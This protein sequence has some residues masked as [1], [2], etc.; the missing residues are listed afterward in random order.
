MRKKKVK[1]G[2]LEIHP[3]RVLEI[4]WERKEGK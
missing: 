4:Q 3:E 2:V 1:K